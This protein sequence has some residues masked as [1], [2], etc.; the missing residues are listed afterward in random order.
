MA[1]RT[2]N[3]QKVHEPQNVFMLQPYEAAIPFT[4]FQIALQQL[5][6]YYRFSG[7]C[8]GR[9][10]VRLSLL[11]SSLIS[12]MQANQENPLMQEQLLAAEQGIAQFLG[13]ESAPGACS[14]RH[15]LDQAPVLQFSLLLLRGI[16]QENYARTGEPAENGALA[17]PMLEQ[18]LTLY[19]LPAM[20]LAER[21]LDRSAS[22][23]LFPEHG[24][25][26]LA[27]YHGVIR[28]LLDL[29]AA[30][31]GRQHAD[32]L[33]YAAFAVAEKINGRL[34]YALMDPRRNPDLNKLLPTEFL[35]RDTPE[36][37]G[38]VR[39]FALKRRPAARTIAQFT[40]LDSATFATSLEHL[41]RQGRGLAQLS[42]DKNIR[43]AE[44]L[45]LEHP[46]WRDRIVL[47]LIHPVSRGQ[48]EAHPSLSVHEYREESGDDLR[49]DIERFNDRFKDYVENNG[50]EPST[51]SSGVSYAQIESR[52][53][54]L[55]FVHILGQGAGA[56]TP[57]C[58]VAGPGLEP[59]NFHLFR[60]R[61]GEQKGA[62][63]E[64]L[65]E[66]QP[67]FYAPSVTVLSALYQRREQRLSKH[68]NYYESGQDC[69]IAFSGFISDNTNKVV[70]KTH[71]ALYPIS[72]GRQR[73]AD[74]EQVLTDGAAARVAMPPQSYE[75]AAPG[76]LPRF[77]VLLTHNAPPVD[78]WRFQDYLTFQTMPNPPADNSNTCPRDAQHTQAAHDALSCVMR[79]DRLTM[80]EIAAGFYPM[81]LVF[82]N[83]C[84][85]E[86]RNQF[87]LWGTFH[88]SDA[89]LVAGADS[90]IGTIRDIP[91]DN[92]DFLKWYFRLLK[93]CRPLANEKH[94]VD[95]L[96]VFRTAMNH[97]IGTAG[98][99]YPM[100]NWAY[101]KFIGIP[102]FA[103]GY[104][105]PQAPA[106]NPH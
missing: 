77:L 25:F 35:I 16:L 67:I 43:I 64:Y 15:V 47:F 28:I 73:D 62:R 26:Y 41:S 33:R 1:A 40:P 87:P 54:E 99:D 75:S 49:A 103:P 36:F 82:L 56:A 86:I 59:I 53:Q 83:S 68:K 32:D 85:T 3:L 14:T 20:I 50:Q 48:G 88:Y 102:E 69:E 4:R 76:T 2:L 24:Q 57:L 91:A 7:N 65:I 74:G 92:T 105:E 101:F 46:Q 98:T 61:I 106:F 90:V 94:C 18:A 31:P 95:K 9:V 72:G 6:S 81:D 42:V 71:A 84:S 93:R 79:D 104:L 8:P 89:F 66:S 27:A 78:L 44:Y 11:H 22:H 100:R 30:E 60:T 34:T 39:A 51:D 37:C 58:I 21:A 38:A 17:V 70:A 13:W 52:I 12:A 19:Y 96:S 63:N 80:A 29:A 45:L 10:N 55:L 23:Y 97:R 5:D